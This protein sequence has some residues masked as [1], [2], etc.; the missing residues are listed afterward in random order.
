M[1]II[2]STYLPCFI[3]F[4]CLSLL[5][6]PYL[7]SCYFHVSVYWTDRYSIYNTKYS[8]NTYPFF[9]MIHTNELFVSYNKGGHFCL[10]E[11][12]LLMEYTFAIKACSN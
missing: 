7:V 1:V 9:S 11:K 10:F 8:T 12:P 3:V 4:P 2:L 6:R 5:D